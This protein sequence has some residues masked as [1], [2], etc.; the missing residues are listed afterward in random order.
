MKDE[1]K[2][3]DVVQDTFEKMWLK[4]DEIPFEK[5]KSYMFTTGYHTMIDRIR[6][7]KKQGS[8]TEA[9][10]NSL[11]VKPENFDLKRIL[12]EALA[13][14]PESQRSVILLRDYEG[15]SYDEIGK[16]MD[17]SESQV[18]I[19]IFRGRKSLQKILGSVEAHL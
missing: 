16:I 13:Q 2:S 14:L 10:T 1:E 3:R 17:L 4:V 8:M 15:Y 5:S 9:K 19:Y 6:R 18:K 7:D 11:A 12:D